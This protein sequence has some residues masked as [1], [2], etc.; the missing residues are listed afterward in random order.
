M[1]IKPHTVSPWLALLLPV[2][3]SLGLGAT[4]LLPHHG[5]GS[6]SSI[7]FSLPIGNEV[8]G[9]SGVKQQESERE[10]AALAGDT[11]F[12]KVEYTP[13]APQLGFRPTQ[14]S[15]SIVLSGHDM[16]NSIHRPERCLPAQGYFNIR[17]SAVG[18]PV[19]NHGFLTMTRLMADLN[20]SP[21]ATKP[22]VIHSLHY[23]VFVGDSNITHNHLMRT[24]LD[25]KDRVLQGKDQRWAY[26]QVSAYYSPENGIS[27]QDAQSTI[28][29][30]IYQILATSINWNTL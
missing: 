16:N 19:M 4:Y 23:Y 17:T 26:V 20:V 6:T 13:T 21:D 1:E 11:E 27:E 24:F 22:K 9:W 3:M 28:E 14:C 2:L 29:A 15:A 18:V 25:M 30:I 10:R 8:Q 5:T 7:K 12:F